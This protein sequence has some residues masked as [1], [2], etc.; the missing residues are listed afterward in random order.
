VEFD[1]LLIYV[2]FATNILA[3]SEKITTFDAINRVQLW[4]TKGIE[5]NEMGPN[6]YSRLGV[7]RSSNPLEIKR[8]Y[9][10]L[11]LSLHPDKN[12][13]PDAADEFVAVKQ[14]Y[15]I[16]MDLE[17]R[18]VYNKFGA[19]GIKNN[20]RFDETQFLI[21]TGVYYLTWGVMAY[22]LTLGKKSGDARQWV[23][24]GLIV[25]LGLEMTMMMSQ[26]NPFPPSLL[27]QTTEYEIVWLLH[28]LFPAFM[29]GCRSMGS[30]LYVDL[31][32]QTRQL[33]LALQEQNKD[34]LLVMRDVQI[35]V[36]N[37]QANG[38]SGG[39][40]RL[41]NVTVGGVAGPQNVVQQ[42]ATPTGKLKELQER[43]QVSNSNVAKA[44]QNLKADEPKSSSF[45]IYSMIIGYF[46][47]S[48]LFK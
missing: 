11:S 9:K 30:Y 36:H 31:D 35:G 29:N 10:K 24:T 15:E 13:S 34:I 7:S 44:V 26:G 37:I 27:P 39:G 4:L 33:L 43:L 16:L 41:A 22:V 3:C 40:H 8:A 25:M 28:A 12:P 21:E 32:G 19:E 45:G 5:M 18:G 6:H 46:I 14:A 23:F 38:V 1:V 20:K 48:F 42:H 47:F 17:F 2:N